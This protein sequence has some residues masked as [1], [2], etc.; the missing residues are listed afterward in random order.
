MKIFFVSL[1]AQNLKQR[2]MRI[3]EVLKE[4]GM[5]RHD[6]ATA[7][8][9][10]D[11]ALSQQLNGNP[12]LTNLTR[13]AEVLHIDIA[14]LFVPVARCPHCGMPISMPTKQ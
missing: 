3:N 5:T 12:S 4:H 8:G 13:I 2:N 11:G 14:E 9:I 10:T 7:L 1:W 6:L